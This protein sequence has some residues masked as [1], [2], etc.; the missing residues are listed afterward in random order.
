M[1]YHDHYLHKNYLAV[2]EKFN[3]AYRVSS[4]RLQSWDYSSNGTYYIT[5]CT[6]NMENHFGE[7]VKGIMIL[8]EKGNIANQY[9]K[10][11]PDH[12]PFVNLDT[13]TI[14]PNHLHGILEIN[15]QIKKVT[16]SMHTGLNPDENPGSISIQGKHE[17]RSMSSQM[18]LIS[19]KAGSLS[20]IIRSYKS[21]VKKWCTDQHLKFNW[22]ARYYDRIVRNMTELEEIR[23]YIIQNPEDWTK[24]KSK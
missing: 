7:I 6:K 1:I 19:P 5:I 2:E 20:T 13:F 23:K 4:S 15:N 21:A 22:H 8:S 14:M 11:I 17:I 16:P 10:D 12:F 24:R 3:D 18:A 9:W